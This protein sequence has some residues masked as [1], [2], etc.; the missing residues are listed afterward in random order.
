ML[1]LSS[2]LGDL[3]RLSPFFYYLTG[4]PLVNGLQWGHAAVLGGLTG[5]LV[6]ASMVLFNRRDL[7]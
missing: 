3:A 2:A 4:D 1:S 6:A 5:A 7:R